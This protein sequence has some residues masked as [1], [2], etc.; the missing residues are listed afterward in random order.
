MSTVDVPKL[1]LRYEGLFDFDGLYAAITDWA[2]NY[3]YM[4]HEVDYKHKF[5]SPKGAEQEFKWE[6]TKKISEFVDYKILVT[7]HVW[8]M[9]EVEIDVGGRKKSLSNARVSMVMEG[10]FT[11]DR[12]HIFKKGRFGELFGKWYDKLFHR[13]AAEY[14]DQLFYRTQGLHAVVKKYFDMQTKKHI[15]KGYLGEN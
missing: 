3:N 5:P 1:T 11:L 2:K 12:Q 6:L 10:S 8:D 13:E 14:Y 15:Y 4:W 9:S 7:V